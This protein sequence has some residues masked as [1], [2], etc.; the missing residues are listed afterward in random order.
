MLGMPKKYFI[1]ESLQNIIVK[2]VEPMMYRRF[3][4]HIKLT[5]LN[6]FKVSFCHVKNLNIFTTYDMF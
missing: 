4:R 5:R 2:M 6:C 3:I 1:P